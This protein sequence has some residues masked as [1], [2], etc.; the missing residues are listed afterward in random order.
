M[1]RIATA[2]VALSLALAGPPEDLG[3]LWRAAQT[4]LGTSDYDGAIELLTRMYEQVALD[5]EAKAQRLRVQWALHEAHLGA[6]KVD[7]DP[8]HLHVARDLVQKYRDDLAEEQTAKRGEADAALAQIDAEIANLEAVEEPEQTPVE[9]EEPPTEPPP[10]APTEPPPPAATPPPAGKPS[11]GLIIGGSVLL[12]VGAAG[13]GMLVGGLVSAGRGIDTF[14]T[15]PSNRDNARDQIRRGNAVAVAG[16]VLSA[17]FV[18]SGSVLL[19]IGLRRRG[20]ARYSFQTAIRPR[21][22]AVALIH[23]F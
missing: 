5:A 15:D 18:V 6:Y 11:Q 23:R 14:E 19:A 10:P 4:R 3:E 2:V 16:G 20:T 8:Q 7:A 13:A 1:S 17:V 22:A 9:S 12:G 21:S